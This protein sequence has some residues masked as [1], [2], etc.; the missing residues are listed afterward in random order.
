MKKHSPS[1]PST[2]ITQNDETK[3]SSRLEIEIPLDQVS[4]GREPVKSECALACVCWD[5]G[6]NCVCPEP[7]PR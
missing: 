7:W 1:A 6:T 2:T 4:G 3:K 5:G